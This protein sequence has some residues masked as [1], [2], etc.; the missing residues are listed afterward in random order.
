[1][2]RVGFLI[3]AVAAIAIAIALVVGAWWLRSEAVEG[4]VR[5]VDGD[6]LALA[7]RRIRLRGMDAPELG[8]TCERNGQPYACGQTA[9]DALR[10]L[11]GDGPVTCRLSGRD[12][13]ERALGQCVGETGDL[14]SRMVRSGLAIAYG[15]YEAEELSARADRAGLWA[16]TFERPADWRR[17]HDFKN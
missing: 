1:M 8:Q 12:R 4:R 11:I 6:T 9:R 10:T 16:G 17:R 15:A 13:F 2:R 7:G 3:D 5:V 14:G